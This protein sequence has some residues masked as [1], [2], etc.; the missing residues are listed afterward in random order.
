MEFM[1]L[2]YLKRYQDKINEE[3]CEHSLTSLFLDDP[4][5]PLAECN[6]LFYQ[7]F[8]KGMKE[9]G[10]SQDALCSS[11][12]ARDMCIKEAHIPFLMEIFEWRRKE[13]FRESWTEVCGS[14]T[15]PEP[16]D[17]VCLNPLP[18]AKFFMIFS[19]C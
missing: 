19:V 14:W 7:E 10:S 17:E 3:E 11:F 13:L 15:P 16:M 4:T 2:Q 5:L 6:L 12:V 1:R 18:L 8:L 9:Y